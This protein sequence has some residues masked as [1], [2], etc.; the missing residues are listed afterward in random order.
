MRNR[1]P[2]TDR[3][4]NSLRYFCVAKGGCQI[5]GAGDEDGGWGAGLLAEAALLASSKL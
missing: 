4:Q 2:G 3:E 1:R 5:A